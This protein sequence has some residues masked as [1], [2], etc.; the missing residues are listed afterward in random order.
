MVKNLG[1]IGFTGFLVVGMI[2]LSGCIG[3]G[4]KKHNLKVLHA[5]SL[6]IQN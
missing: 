2:V 1:F 6:T 3:G 4:E 5:G